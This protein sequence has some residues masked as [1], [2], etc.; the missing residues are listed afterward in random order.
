M[1]LDLS[2]LPTG[3]SGWLAL[4][5]YARGLGDLSEV[6]WLE[7]KG[8]LPFRDKTDKKRSAVTLAR[9]VLGMANRMPDR[10]AKNLGGHGV[11]LVGITGTDIQGTERV[12]GAVFY[13][14][15]NPYVGQDGLHWDYRYLQHPEGLVLAL[16]VDPP[17]WGDPVFTFQKE[18]SDGVTKI[19]EGEILVRVPGKTR[20]S[21][22]TDMRD[23]QR[24]LQG[25][26]A[27]AA[28][29]DAS[30]VGRFHR[31]HP[32]AATALV[33]EYADRV[34]ESRLSEVPRES[35]NNPALTV[36]AFYTGGAERRQ[37]FRAEVQQWRNSAAESATQVGLEFLR[38]ELAK[39]HLRIVN[40]SDLY[41]ED[42]RV[43]FHFPLGVQALPRDD[44]EYRHRGEHFNFRSVLPNPPPRWSEFSSPAAS[45][46]VS[47]PAT[48]RTLPEVPM[49][50]SSQLEVEQ[51][52]DGIWVTWSLGDLR[53]R[54]TVTSEETIALVTDSDLDHL[55]ARWQV[56]ARGINHVFSGV[57]TIECAQPPSVHSQWHFGTT[58]SPGPEGTEPPAS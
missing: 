58:P 32:G 33:Q 46:A 42:A 9:P 35:K 53:P 6:D 54:D 31:L 14:A 43:R 28:S 12:D 4:V 8:A 10:A 16:V 13:D 41:L 5:D 29:V 1:E 47:I 50:R 38:H 23:L 30:I 24:R 51:V 48:R 15:L 11:V 21:T 37:E 25:S 17:K 45:L 40:D 57:T 27:A 19:R 55:S 36:T 39:E 22:S 44:T 26:P 56:T 34:A 52:E 3:D 2:R 7:L 49:I 20:P 18:F